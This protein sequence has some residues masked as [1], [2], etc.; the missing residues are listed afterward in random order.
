MT[1]FRNRMAFSDLFS[2]SFFSQLQRYPFLAALLPSLQQTFSPAF[3]FAQRLR[4]DLRLEPFFPT[5]RT[6]LI[7]FGAI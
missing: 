3:C 7:I 1:F 2:M 5:K 4:R 6:K